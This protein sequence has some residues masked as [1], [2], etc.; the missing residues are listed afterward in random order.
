MEYGKIDF[1]SIPCPGYKLARSTDHD[2]LT[3]NQLFCHSDLV[4]DFVTVILSQSEG[5]GKMALGI[6]KYAC[7]CS[8]QLISV[9]WFMASLSRSVI[10][11]PAA[12]GNGV[13]VA[14]F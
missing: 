2:K 9:I 8:F 7:E 10:V 6:V 1:H 13:L 5:L 4:I 3:A 14:R 11:D 12:R